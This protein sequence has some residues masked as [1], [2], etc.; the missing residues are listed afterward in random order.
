MQRCHRGQLL[1]QS[2]VLWH[3]RNGSIHLPGG[4]GG[5][6]ETSAEATIG[7]CRYCR[8]ATARLTALSPSRVS[9]RGVRPPT[10]R[11][12]LPA[13]AAGRR[14]AWDLQPGTGGATTAGVRALR[15]L[16]RRDPRPTG[17]AAIRRLDTGTAREWTRR[18]AAAATLGGPVG[19]VGQAVLHD[20]TGRTTHELDVIALADG[21]QLHARRAV[22]RAIGEAKATNRP[23]PVGDLHRLERIRVPVTRRLAWSAGYGA[24]TGSP[25]APAA[26]ACRRS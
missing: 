20:P 12:E 8:P 25:A 21:E 26:S 24:R 23:R 11:Q 6:D 10:S 5:A 3:I 1:A 14:A 17:A 18:F 22:I 9:R 13:P 2:C 4:V 19:I 7:S 16:C 15:A